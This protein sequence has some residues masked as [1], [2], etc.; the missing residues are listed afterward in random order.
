MVRSASSSS[1]ERTNQPEATTVLCPRDK[2]LKCC[3]PKVLGPIAL[4]CLAA[5]GTDAPRT[6]PK[7]PPTA[8]DVEQHTWA[9]RYLNAVLTQDMAAQTSCLTHLAHDWPA[10]LP[11]LPYRAVMHTAYS[12]DNLADS[13]ARFDL[14][15]ALFDAHYTPDDGIGL[16]E[17]WRDL[18]LAHLDHGDSD[19]AVTA[20]QAVNSPFVLIGVRIDNRFA[21]VR[22]RLGA[23]LDIDTAMAAEISRW[24]TRVQEHPMELR[25]VERLAQ[26]LV[27]AQRSAEALP[28]LDAAISRLRAH[29]S[30][31]PAYF[32][33]ST[34]YNWIL[35]WR[36]RALF[37][38][39]RLDDAV[40]QE[41]L[42]SQVPE[43]G[44]PNVSQTINLSQLYNDVGRP[45]DALAALSNFPER[46][47][48]SSGYVLVEFERLRAALQLRD[49]ALIDQTAAYL[50]NHRDTAAGLLQ[51]AL[52]YLGRI[53]EAVGLYTTR[54]ADPRERLTAL[55]EAQHYPGAAATPQLE[56]ESAKWQMFLALPTVQAAIS[57][58]GVVEN[59]DIRSR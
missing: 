47:V 32:D 34:E 16:D 9:S 41:R 42:A 38:L 51:Y 19:A 54:L 40:A 20:L 24:R 48:S 35:E 59:F 25:S 10:S 15:Q 8:V 44:D 4:L 26:L 3:V 6:S 33:E 14:L 30:G 36:S 29:Q 31:H 2:R 55:L 13:R 50:T 46:G 18:A 21:A 27:A 7:D 17:L 56:A 1:N 11:T 45:S 22:Q 52:V 53:Q 43:R 49:E 39:A 37:Q 23:R 5:C 58:V 28:L 57:T 12:S